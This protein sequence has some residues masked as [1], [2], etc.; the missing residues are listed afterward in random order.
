MSKDRSV[1]TAEAKAW[2]ENLRT[3]NSVAVSTV[4]YDPR[5]QQPI[6]VE[7]SGK[8]GTLLV[9]GVA[10]GC[11]EWSDTRKVWCIQDAAGRCLDHYSVVHGEDQD[12][13]GAVALAKIMLRNGTLPTPEQ[14]ALIRK[15]QE[16]AAAVAV[17]ADPPVPA[18]SGTRKPHTTDGGTS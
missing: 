3:A 15:E 5:R 7:W 18:K 2:L 6:T 8:I 16:R 4:G 11:V 17:V 10:W 14:A 12:R 9:N 1:V 13:A